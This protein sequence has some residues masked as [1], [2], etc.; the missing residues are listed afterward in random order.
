MM[1]IS[2]S[3]VYQISPF[4]VWVFNH[5]DLVGIAISGQKMLSFTLIDL[6]VSEWLGDPKL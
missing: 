1:D 4:W 6:E 2:Q 5:C 3:N